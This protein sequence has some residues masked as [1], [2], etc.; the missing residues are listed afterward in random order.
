MI[1]NFAASWEL[2]RYTYMAGWLIAFVLSMTGVV[3]VARNQIFLG[4]AVSQASTFGIASAMWAG[5]AFVT[6]PWLVSDNFLSIMAV[7]TSVLGAL[8]IS[9]ES[10]AG[11]ESREAVTGW[12]FLL[13]ASAAILLVTR[14]PHGIE[15]IHRIQS[16]SIIGASAQ[17]FTIFLAFALVTATVATVARAKLL[18]L[19]MDPAMAAAMGLKTRR[20]SAAIAVWI[21][22]TVGVAIKSSGMLYTFG[23][24]VLPAL[25]AKNLCREVGS[26][27]AVSA[28]IGAVSAL[29]GF[30]MA[31][32]YDYPPGQL[33]V[34]VLSTVVAL[35]WIRRRFS[36]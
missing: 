32:H 10:K 9:W 16:S 28:V 14:S 23:C 6:H 18:L 11:G 35:T 27:F 4:A 33:T 22:L 8:I 20:W 5:S 13:A 31:N 25:A 24:L 15:E 21:G 7:S 26:M 1:D 17:E 3:V 36:G 29:L 12:V 30:L 19:I 2:F 34:A